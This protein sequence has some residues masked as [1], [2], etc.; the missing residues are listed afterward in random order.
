VIEGAAEYPP[1]ADYAAIGD[2]GTAAL[3]SRSGGIDWLGLPHFSGPAVFSALLDRRWGGHFTVA[4]TGPA[5]VRRRYLDNTNILETTFSTATG[6]LRLVDTMSIGA[7]GGGIEPLREIIRVLEVLAG[8]VEI[9]ISY[10]P[11]F[12]FGR[13]PARLR[14]RG[15]LGWS[16]AHAEHWLLLRTELPLVLNEAQNGLR[17][18]VR[19]AAGEKHHLCL[20]Y[21]RG[22]PGI[23]PLLGSDADQRIEATRRWWQSWCAACAYNGP[24]REAVQRS[25]LVLKLL[26]Y[27]VS[28]AVIA[29]PTTSLPEHVGG[30]RNWDYRF[31]WLRDASLS[32]SAF[33][34]LGFHGEAE[35]F[36]GWLLHATRLTWPEL[37]VLY[38]IYGEAEIPE[39]TLAHP[40]GYRGSR[41]VRIGNAAHAQFQLDS[42]GALIQA[43]FDFV[44]SGGRLA[45]E[46]QS[47]LRQLGET[48]CRLWS[49][50]DHGIWEVRGNPRHFVFSK[51]MCW[52][53]LDRLLALGS[54]GLSTQ[55]DTKF[56]QH[57]D[58]IRAAIESRGYDPGVGSYIAAFDA[59]GEADA[60][61]LQIRRLGFHNADDPRL[62]GTE[63]YVRR[64][65]GQPRG[66][67]ARYRTEGQ[68]AL[69]PGEGAFI[70]CAF[71]A[72]EAR[73]RGGDKIGAAH[74]FE[75]LLALANDVGLFA[76][77]ISP[78]SGDMLGNFPQAFSHLALI[79]AALAL[80]PEGKLA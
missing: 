74:E 22:E 59:A 61:L 9:N 50:P 37:Q 71:W 58:A 15:A 6:R 53:A 40:A 80:Q 12:D 16:C 36:L 77:E 48:V 78:D 18:Q 64:C 70:A 76:E 67:I 66:L 24:F 32:L 30:V 26:T 51:L 3:V 5:T 69:P 46:E 20:A 45:A 52:V 10:E 34:S 29:A 27:A 65:L 72:A 41:P 73:A 11:R 44:G 63:A 1:I 55:N 19:L 75:G 60:A 14:Q 8:E 35:A 49:Q 39:H 13:H 17:C 38:D 68:D 47:L 57:R 21:T 4:P 23:V 43:A 2:C 54:M 62:I 25:A 28:G 56:R 7:V 31:C 42:Y 33:L 79:N